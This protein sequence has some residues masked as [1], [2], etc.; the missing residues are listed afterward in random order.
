MK[1]IYKYILFSL[2][3][4]LNGVKQYKTVSKTKFVAAFSL[5]FLFT[6]FST[7]RVM[8][9][10]RFMILKKKKVDNLWRLLKK[11]GHI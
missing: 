7:H 9:K 2:N 11:T 10:Q 5:L 1:L 3:I 6:S 4:E 8:S